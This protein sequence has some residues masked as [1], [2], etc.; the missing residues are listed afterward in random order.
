MNPHGR[1]LVCWSV[2]QNFLK[3]AGSYTFILQ[4]KTNFSCTKRFPILLSGQKEFS[5]EIR[6]YAHLK[7]YA[8]DQS[9]ILVQN[10]GPKFREIESCVVASKDL[11]AI[12]IRNQC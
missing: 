1:L 4:T 9:R 12:K 7:E 5:V 6:V 2:C 3:G 10:N 11:P 8:N